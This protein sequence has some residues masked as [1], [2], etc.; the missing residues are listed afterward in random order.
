MRE[1]PGAVRNSGSS[2]RYSVLAA[3]TRDPKCP[4]GWPCSRPEVPRRRTPARVIRG[5]SA[6]SPGMRDSFGCER[7][8]QNPCCPAVRPAAPG[9]AAQME[10]LP[11]VMGSIRRNPHDALVAAGGDRLVRHAIE[12]LAA[13]GFGIGGKESLR[14][15][16]ELDFPLHSHADA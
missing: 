2:S 12:P 9:P 8:R 1:F 16:T 15:E 3:A 14:P 5:G 11:A 13:E 10:R 4:G 7:P 6:A